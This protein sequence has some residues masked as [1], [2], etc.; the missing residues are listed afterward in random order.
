MTIGDLSL[1]E[2]ELSAADAVDICRLAGAGWDVHPLHSPEIAVA[3]AVCLLSTRGG[4]SVDDAVEVVKAMPAADLL[5][6]ITLE[7]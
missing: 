7:G 4:H 3:V 6:C 2:S 1:I 5:A